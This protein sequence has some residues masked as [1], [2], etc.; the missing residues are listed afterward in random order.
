[1]AAPRLSTAVCAPWFDFVL[2]LFQN[3]LE[4]H[5]VFEAGEDRDGKLMAPDVSVE[6]GELIGRGIATLA[7]GAVATPLAGVLPF[8]EPGEARTPTV[9]R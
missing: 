4:H 6:A 2:Q 3:F 9:R 5:W 1:V 8:I 7:L